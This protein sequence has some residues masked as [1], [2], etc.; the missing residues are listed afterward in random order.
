MAEVRGNLIN[1]TATLMT[2]YPDAQ[3]KADEVLFSKLGRHWQDLGIND[4]VDSKMWDIFMKAYQDSS[5][6]KETAFITLG[7]KIYPA[8]KRAGQI[9]N[10]I[11]TPLKM[12]RF[13]G[14]G[15]KLY[16]RG[17][18]VKPRTFIRLKE[19]DVLVDAPSPG[20]DCKVIEGVFQGIIEM[21]NIKTVAV[22]QTKCVKKGQ[23]TCEYHI[24]W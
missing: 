20:Y 19:H 23:S 15:F 1:L 9:P 17:P 14:E 12:L 3:K 16:H 22:K 8:I 4:W 13:E 24:T 18:D 10:D 6:S 7:R 5:P 21:F 11:D 2:L